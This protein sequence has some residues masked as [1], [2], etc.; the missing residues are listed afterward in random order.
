MK[1]AVQQKGRNARLKGYRLVGTASDGTWLLSPQTSHFTEAEKVGPP[2]LMHW[3]AKTPL[4]QYNEPYASLSRARIGS[5]G[6]RQVAKRA[7]IH[8]LDHLHNPSL[9]S[10]T[11][12]R[13]APRQ[14]VGHILS[15]G[16]TCVHPFWEHTLVRPGHMYA[17][18]PNRELSAAVRYR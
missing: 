16:P 14:L 6:F 17:V 10:S 9:P 11:V 7:R 5:E 18:S 15:A 2:L 13:R 4:R 3:P 1:K 12:N 8:T